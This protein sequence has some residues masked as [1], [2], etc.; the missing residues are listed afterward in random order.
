MLAVLQCALAFN[1]GGFNAPPLRTATRVAASPM[2]AEDAAAEIARLQAQIE[3]ARLQAQIQAL[4]LNS[5]ESAAPEAAPMPQ[6]VAQVASEVA[7]EAAASSPAE[8]LANAIDTVR[9]A[10]APAAA[11]VASALPD[12]VSPEVAQMATAGNAQMAQ[13]DPVIVGLAVFAAF[14][15]TAFAISAFGAPRARSPTP[16]RARRAPPIQGSS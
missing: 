15:V 2:M 6:A 14:P 9:E 3:I 11:S 12:A 16:A 1:V 4:Q 7:P 10:V 5:A 13:M 8:V